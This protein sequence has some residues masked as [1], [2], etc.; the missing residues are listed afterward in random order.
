MT[1]NGEAR[2]GFLPD[3]CQSANLLRTMLFAQLLA[4]IL[5]AVRPGGLSERIEA[6]AL[7]TLFIQWI[8]ILDVA[9]L[10]GLRARLE[11]LDRRLAA[12]LAFVL[13]QL[14]TVAVTLVGYAISA[15]VGLPIFGGPLSQAL[16]EH[17]LIS[18]I[19]TALGLRYFYVT[20]EWRR[21]VESEAQARVAA[22]QARIR[23]HFLF[24]SMNTIASLTRSNAPA[25]EEAVEDL[26]ELLRAT[27]SD[28]PLSTLANEIE[29]AA[30]YLRIEA[31]RLGSRL[32]VSWDVDRAAQGARLPALTL[33]PLVEN[34][35]YH[36]I[37]RRAEG[38]TVSLST[39][40]QG[41]RV[42][43]VVENPAP[44]QPARSDGHRLAQDNVRQRLRLQFGTA[45]HFAIEQSGER[46]RVTIEVPMEMPT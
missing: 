36:G 16:A 11:R 41:E 14:V 39:Q 7:I 18:A 46:Y 12:G 21:R 44:A 20:A 45:G 43:I 1:Q 8:A 22:L 5:V 27:L 6:L 32:Q 24:N 2:G 13:L 9:L 15:G 4:F 31:S 23:P 30:S 28:Q 35:V 17:A 25:A 19:V 29:L 38:G 10:C 3:F 26:S 40:L 37:E 34:A 42:R 33:Q